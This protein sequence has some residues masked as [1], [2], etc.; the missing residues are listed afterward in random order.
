M[1]ERGSSPSHQDSRREWDEAGPGRL[2][3]WER[4]EPALSRFA[5]GTRAV[6]LPSW[7]EGQHNTTLLFCVTISVTSVGGAYK[8]HKNRCSHIVV[9]LRGD[10]AERGHGVTCG[11]VVLSSR[12]GAAALPDRQ[13]CRRL[14]LPADIRRVEPGGVA[15]KSRWLR[16]VPWAFGVESSV[17]NCGLMI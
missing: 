4:R 5:V 8:R 11:A 7:L 6:L 9:F 14:P 3:Q 2:T 10:L 16:E 13:S 1:C 17:F 15:R 12:G